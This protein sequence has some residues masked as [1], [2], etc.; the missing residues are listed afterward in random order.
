[1]NNVDNRINDN[2]ASEC[3][4][5]GLHTVDNEEVGSDK[6]EKDFNETNNT[7]VDNLS[8]R[9]ENNINVNNT[10]STLDA[11]SSIL[12]DISAAIDSD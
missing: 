1:M 3:E 10:I 12:D 6:T 7:G 8:R 4:S 2:D 9:A 5:N 11:D